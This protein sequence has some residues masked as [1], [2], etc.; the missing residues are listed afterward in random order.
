MI[1]S[2]DQYAK[3]SEGIGRGAN[4]PGGE[5]VESLAHQQV[6]QLGMKVQI[7][8]VKRGYHT[9]AWRVEITLRA[10]RFPAR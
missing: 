5:A 7:S 6:T 4:S 10:S 2:S 1:N 9:W 3:G 8:T